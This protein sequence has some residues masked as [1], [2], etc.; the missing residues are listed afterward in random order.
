MKIY[1]C[2][3]FFQENLV[4]NLRF[5]I[6][7]EVVDKFIVC[8]SLYD[9]KGNKKK[10]NFCLDNK[11]L[12]NKVSH[13]ILN[14][15]FPEKIISPWDRQAYQREY[16]FKGIEDANDEDY[17]MFSDPDEIPNPLIL[18]N[19]NLNKK[20]GIFLQKCFNFKINLLN[21]NETPWEG[22]RIVKKKFLK[23]FNF[24]RQKILKK[25]IKKWWNLNLEKS[26]Q[27]FEDG[28]WHFNNLLTI[29][30]ISLKLKTFAHS[31]YN[32]EEFTSIENIKEKIKNKKDLF[33]RGNIL[34]K[35]PL[36]SNFPEAILNNKK[37]YKD[38][39]I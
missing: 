25:N 23:S 21:I 10:I 33:N 39:I 18:K 26:I 22:T 13:L 3:T 24:M 37:F 11:D 2:I 36:D 34:Q 5:E 20:Y 32:K 7:K 14:H 19:L 9:H 8:E 31:E 27:I 28:G 16:I 1:D 15:P 38:F 6:L 29:D 12:S 35:I 30:Q 4:T 17:V